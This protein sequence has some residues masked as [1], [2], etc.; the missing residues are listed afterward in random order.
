VKN[1]DACLLLERFTDQMAVRADTGCP[2]AQFTGILFGIAGKL[3]DGVG[4]HGGMHS[5]K[6]GSLDELG[7][8]DEAFE[9]ID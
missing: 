6:K 2:P 3:L 9:R 4:G 1:I 5:N 8:R 7:D